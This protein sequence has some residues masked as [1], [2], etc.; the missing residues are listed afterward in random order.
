MIE[1]IEFTLQVMTP[2][3]RIALRAAYPEAKSDAEAL[4]RRILERSGAEEQIKAMVPDPDIDLLV[5]IN[6][7]YAIYPENRIGLSPLA[8]K[9]LE[10]KH[11]SIFAETDAISF[12]M[13][14]VYDYVVAEALRWALL[15]WPGRL[16][17]KVLYARRQFA[18]E[19]AKE[20]SEAPDEEES[21]AQP[22]T[23]APDSGT[24]HIDSGTQHIDSSTE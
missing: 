14:P 20:A 10:H 9:A 11:S 16:D 21:T 18:E 3:E 8:K 15:K 13:T 7:I 17:L 22:G 5:A 24:Q 23:E 19:L 12:L 2:E 4:V 6:I 1:K